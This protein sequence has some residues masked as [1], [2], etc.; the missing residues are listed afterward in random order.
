M[1][2]QRN[3][4]KIGI[5]SCLFLPEP[6]VSSHT[7]ADLAEQLRG[8]GHRVRV[9]TSFP[10]RPNGKLYEGYK[11]RL[12]LYDRSFSRYD[13][14]RC[15]SFVS[16]ASTL[17]S[18]FLENISFGITSGLAVLFLEKPDVLYGNTWPIFA[19]GILV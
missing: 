15:F 11:R 13:V 4:M 18:R 17:L 2:A 19:Q 9:I 10:S 12:W 16:P 7:G 1:Q 14:L 5:V 6:I 8:S 3:S